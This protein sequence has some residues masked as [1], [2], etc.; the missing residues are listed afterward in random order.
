MARLS[1]RLR[2]VS[3]LQNAQIETGA[4]HS[5]LFRRVTGSLSTAQS[6]FGVK[7][8]IHIHRVYRLRGVTPPLL[9]YLHDAQRD[10]L[11]STL[12][13]YLSAFTNTLSSS[14]TSSSSSPS[15][16]SSSLSKQ[17]DYLT[18]FRPN[19]TS[20]SSTEIF[21]NFSDFPPPVVV[22]SFKGFLQL[23]AKVNCIDK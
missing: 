2:K 19:Q 18:N 15:S 7:L 23:S 5:F 4:N 10:I 1:V 17:R 13:L 3:T 9:I 21:K 14:S 16:S 22:Q 8:T 12:T 6:S 11:I 20:A